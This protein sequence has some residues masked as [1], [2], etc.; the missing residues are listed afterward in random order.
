MLKRY[1][2][3]RTDS[4]GHILYMIFM[5]TLELKEILEI[6]KTTNQLYNAFQMVVAIK[7][8]DENVEWIGENEGNGS[9]SFDTEHII[10]SLPNTVLNSIKKST[11]EFLD[12]EKIPVLIEILSSFKELK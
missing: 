8:D 4:N 7:T 1:S 12:G 2:A 9:V 3:L 11:F 5:P 6:S 10:I